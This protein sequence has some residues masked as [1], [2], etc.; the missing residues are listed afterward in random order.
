MTRHVVPHTPLCISSPHLLIL[1]L[2]APGVAHGCHGSP[3]RKSPTSL[4]SNALRGLGYTELLHSAAST[5]ASPSH[6][7]GEPSSTSSRH[8]LP[9]SIMAEAIG[10]FGTAVGVA[11][12]GIQVCQGLFTYFSAYKDQD[13]VV[14]KANQQISML[15]S[16][17]SL[18]RDLLRSLSQ[19]HSPVVVQ[20]EALV[21]EC[22]SSIVELEVMLERC[23]RGSSQNGMRNRVQRNVQGALF[24]FRLDSLQKLQTDVST[25]QDNLNLAFNLLQLSVYSS[26]KPPSHTRFISVSAN[27]FYLEASALLHPLAV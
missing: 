14:Q 18:T 13:A 20:V 6:V 12:L 25:I 21:I 2:A 15:T 24:P 1:N 7:K 11:S 22:R 17:L 9:P 8:K 3:Q 26:G 5:T 23:N 4:S 10:T 16:L 19:D 27:T